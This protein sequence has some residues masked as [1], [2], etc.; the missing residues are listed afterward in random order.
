M[1]EGMD[2]GMESD[3]KAVLDA[4]EDSDAEEVDTN[5]VVW[6]HLGEQILDFWNMQ[7]Q[8]LITPLSIAAW[9]CSP[10]E[11]IRKDVLAL[12]DRTRWQ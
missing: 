12:R 7:Q 3:D 6:Q 4:E 9:F 2:N 11:E 5:M 1:D 10:E 8:K